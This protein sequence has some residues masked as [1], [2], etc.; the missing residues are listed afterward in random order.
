MELGL[1]IA[2]EVGL[3]VLNGKFKKTVALVDKPSVYASASVTTDQSANCQNGV[4]IRAGVKNRIYASVLELYDY[5]IRT[6]V[7]FE[8][9]LG[10]VTYVPLPFCVYPST[11]FGT[12]SA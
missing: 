10:C 3:D 9:G 5:D 4:E 1:P 12:N 8:K 2:L 11:Y 7:I 6:D